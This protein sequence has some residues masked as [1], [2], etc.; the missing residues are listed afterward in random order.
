MD[1]DIDAEFEFL[2]HYENE[3]TERSQQ[4]A[5]ALRHDFLKLD[6]ILQLRDSIDEEK[7]FNFINNVEEQYFKVCEVFNELSYYQQKSLK[8][9]KLE[10]EQRVIFQKVSGLEL[11]LTKLINDICSS[12]LYKLELSNKSKLSRYLQGLFVNDDMLNDCIDLINK[13]DVLIDRFASLDEILSNAASKRKL[14][15]FLANNNL[16]DMIVSLGL[17]QKSCSTTKNLVLS[18]LNVLFSYIIAKPS[19]IHPETLLT[20]EG[21]IEEDVGFYSKKKIKLL[22]MIVPK[23]VNINEFI[24]IRRTDCFDLVKLIIEQYESRKSYDVARLTH[25]QFFKNTIVGSRFFLPSSLKLKAKPNANDNDIGENNCLVRVYRGMI[26]V[27]RVENDFLKSLFADDEKLYKQCF[28]LIIEPLFNYINAECPREFS[29]G[30]QNP[31]PHLLIHETLVSIASVSVLINSE[32]IMKQKELR[33]FVIEICEKCKVKI[34]SFFENL[35]NIV[36]LNQNDIVASD[37]CPHYL[38]I[39]TLWFCRL[40]LPYDDVFN[41]LFKNQKCTHMTDFDSNTDSSFSKKNHQSSSKSLKT[42][43]NFCLPIPNTIEFDLLANS[44]EVFTI[45][46]KELETNETIKHTPIS[47]F[48]YDLI[49]VIID[50]LD[51]HVISNFEKDWKMI[52]WLLNNYMYIHESLNSPINYSLVKILGGA[53]KRAIYNKIEEKGRKLTSKISQPWISNLYQNEVVS[54]INHLKEI[55]EN[56]LTTNN[57]NLKAQGTQLA[58]EIIQLYAP[59][60]RKFKLDF[61]EFLK[62]STAISIYSSELHDMF[63]KQLHDNFVESY[64]NLF[65]NYNSVLKDNLFVVK[66]VNK[67]FSYTDNEIEESINRTFSS[68]DQFNFH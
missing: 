28:Q 32:E 17:K 65:D 35:H 67:V 58:N 57:M 9:S 4:Y 48:I 29:F 8:Y 62:E 7:I 11:E 23:V 68:L 26:A 49:Y 45:Q 55:K 51:K 61:E 47:C 59:L 21:T 12:E 63:C 43:L 18:K 5:D 13:T 34:G 27:I 36:K 54:K 31:S 60:Y 6:E 22:K 40:I 52:V 39:L 46:K 25:P 53:F 10:S 30:L 64:R 15:D 38:T 14:D 16:N 50:V 19:N 42:L 37:Y 66:N 44:G 41:H 56:I 20:D 3:I 1:Y 33:N 24:Q 2:K